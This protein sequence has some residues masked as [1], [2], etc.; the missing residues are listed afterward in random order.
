[1]DFTDLNKV[2]LKDSCPLSKIDKLVDVMAGH[3]LL[4]FMDTFSGYHQIPLYPKDEEKATFITDHDLH[5]YK[6]MPFIL[7]IAGATY[8]R[9]VNTPHWPDHGSLYR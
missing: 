7:K 9:L 1:M 8:Q 3:A 6:M 4:S 2:C 5:Y